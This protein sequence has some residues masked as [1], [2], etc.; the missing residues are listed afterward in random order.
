[1]AQKP[2]YARRVRLFAAL[3]VLTLAVV[4]LSVLYL[5]G[6]ET[7]YAYNVP[8]R[9]GAGSGLLCLRHERTNAWERTSGAVTGD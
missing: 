3:V 4:V 6:P 8:Q 5:T 1:M 7:K 9:P 2:R